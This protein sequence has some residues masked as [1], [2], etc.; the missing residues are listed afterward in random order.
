MIAVEEAPSAGAVRIVLRP[1]GSMT[2]GQARLLVAAMAGAMGAIALFFAALGAWMVLPFSGAE[3]LL[4][5]LALGWAQRKLATVEIITIQGQSVSV[6]VRRFSSGR[7]YRFD[8]AW[9]RL[10]RVRSDRRGH[11]SRLFLRR[12]RSSLE[13]GSFLI[14]EERD[15]LVH[16]LRRFL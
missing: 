15:R 10:E 8:K 12:Q 6:E 1:N 14:E 11:P 2:P 16:E 4:L 3:W 7:S 13:I 5:A 9:L